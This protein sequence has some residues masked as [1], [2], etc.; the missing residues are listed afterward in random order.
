LHDELLQSLFAIRQDLAQAAGSPQRRD[1]VIL[2]RDGVG[3]A[4]RTLRAA[5]FDLHPVVLDQ[6]GLRSAV[7]AVAGI[8]ASWAAS[9]SASMSRR[10]SRVSTTDCCSHS[11]ASCSR[12]SPAIPEPAKPVSGSGDARLEVSDDGRGIDPV[13][14]QQAVARGHIGLAS[15]AQRLEALGGGFEVFRRPSGGTTARGAIPI[16]ATPGPD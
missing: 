3:E 2:A 8:T 10:R 7:G 5:V 4:I 11:C 1:L 9:M 15:A 13:E 6:G 14:A 12:T 16:A